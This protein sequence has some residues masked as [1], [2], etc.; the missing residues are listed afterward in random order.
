MVEQV[1]LRCAGKRMAR[2]AEALDMHVLPITSHSP[3]AEFEAMLKAAHAISL[4]CPLTPSTSGML[5]C[6]EFGL[7]RPGMMIVNYARGEVI[8]KEVQ[9][10]PSGQSL[11]LSLLWQSSPVADSTEG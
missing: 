11:F 8:D 9:A 6:A 2:S 4:H 7:M 10:L 1:L 3:R 5:G